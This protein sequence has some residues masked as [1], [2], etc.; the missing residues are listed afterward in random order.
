SGRLHRQIGRFFP[1]EDAIDVASRSPVIIRQVGSIREQSAVSDEGA[2]GIDGGQFIPRSER[3]D[4][5]AMEDHRRVLRYDQ[6][7]ACLARECSYGLL[8][9]PWVL[10][11]DRA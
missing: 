9:L 5:L 10:R 6:S 8:G 7:T 2:R 11:V 3:N 1:L 4:Q